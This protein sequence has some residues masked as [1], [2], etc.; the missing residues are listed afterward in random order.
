[1]SGCPAK[2]VRR[3]LLRLLDIIDYVGSDRDVITAAED[4]LNDGHMIFCSVKPSTHTSL[5]ALCNST[6]DP[7]GKPH[8]MNVELLMNS[9]QA[10]CSCQAGCTGRSARCKH[11]VA[12]LLRASRVGID[13]LEKLSSKQLSDWEKAKQDPDWYKPKP[14]CELFGGER[15]PPVRSRPLFS[16][17]QESEMFAKLLAAAPDSA[18]AM[19]LRATKQTSE[20]STS[21]RQEVQQ[22]HQEDIGAHCHEDTVPKCVQEMEPKESDL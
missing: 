17:E 10:T 2:M 16:D 21:A 3:R 4:L 15:R 5:I 12:A 6:K 14:L 13:R 9:I 7:Y 1:M 22:D 20:Q 19:M 11:V 8:E 18:L